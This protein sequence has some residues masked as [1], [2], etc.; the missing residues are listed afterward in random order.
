MD[1]LRLLYF[2]L[3]SR[4]QVHV[5]AVVEGTGVGWPMGGQ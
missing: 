2:S 1:L 4:S 3:T 5:E